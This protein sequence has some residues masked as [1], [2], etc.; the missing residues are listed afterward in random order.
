LFTARPESGEGVDCFIVSFEDM[1][2][3]EAIKLLMLSYLLSVCH[4]AGVAAVQLP[5]ELVDDELRVIVDVKSLDPELDSDAQAINKG[6]VLWHIVC[7]MEIQSNHL[8]E[9]ISL[10]GDQYNT[11]P[12]PVESEGAAKVHAPVLLANR[13]MRLLIFGPFHHEVRKG[14]RLDHRLW[15]VCYV[16]P[17]ELKGPLGNPSHGEA[18]SDN[19]LEPV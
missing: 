18:I 13:D 17:H 14:L 5:H 3:F 8:E 4:H 15:D 2:K 7:C 10:G 11:S 6:F 1:M 19:F 12:S 9:L 16:E